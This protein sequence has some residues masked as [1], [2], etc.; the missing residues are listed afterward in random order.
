MLLKLNYIY[1]GN[2]IAQTRVIYAYYYIFVCTIPLKT[3]QFL[4]L[5]DLADFQRF[6]LPI[7]FELTEL[8]ISLRA[9]WAIF[10]EA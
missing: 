10:G 4:S 3:S 9:T 2:T 7:Y 1:I 8:K 5:K 6:N